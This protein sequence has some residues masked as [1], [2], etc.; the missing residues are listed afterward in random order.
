VGH[1]D[2][3]EDEGVGWH[4]NP[5]LSI[6]PPQELISLMLK[7]RCLEDTLFAVTDRAGH[8]AIVAS[9]TGGKPI[10]EGLEILDDPFEFLKKGI[11]LLCPPGDDF[12]DHLAP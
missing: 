4:S 6:R 12:V 7:D 5:A 1:P 9:N 3:V 8:H 10:Q 2:K 11:S